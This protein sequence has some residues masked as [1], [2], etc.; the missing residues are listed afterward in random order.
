MSVP[1]TPG[2]TVN[3]GCRFTVPL[4][5]LR[6]RKTTVEGSRETRPTVTVSRYTSRPPSRAETVRDRSPGAR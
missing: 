6:V 3:S 5:G 4:L 2:F 1:L